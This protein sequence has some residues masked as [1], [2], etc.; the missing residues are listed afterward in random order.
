MWKADEKGCLRVQ[1]D[2]GRILGTFRWNFAKL[3][4]TIHVSSPPSKTKPISEPTLLAIYNRLGQ[5][6]KDALSLMAYGAER[7]YTLGHIPIKNVYVRAITFIAPKSSSV[8][9]ACPLFDKNG[10]RG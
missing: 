10:R 1:V 5:R 7:I 3:D 9:H 6:D 4:M 2:I 8:D